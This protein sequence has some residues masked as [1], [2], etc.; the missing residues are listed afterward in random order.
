MVKVKFRNWIVKV[1]S[2]IR[3]ELLWELFSRFHREKWSFVNCKKRIII[4]VGITARFGGY[5]W[6]GMGPVTPLSHS[7]QHPRP[8]TSWDT[9][10]PLPKCMLWYTPLDRHTPVKTLSSS[11]FV[12]GR[13]K[14]FIDP[15]NV[16]G[17]GQ[18]IFTVRVDDLTVELSINSKM[19][20]IQRSLLV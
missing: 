18:Y 9:Q 16:M 2:I 15:R 20:G 14:S 7:P 8:S 4:S 17:F 19:F 1:H 10:P 12:Y 11:N 3:P 6:S 5:L 13:F